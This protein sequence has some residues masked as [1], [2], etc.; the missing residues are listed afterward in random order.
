MIL[1]MVILWMT[2]FIAII[3][4][5]VSDGAYVFEANEILTINDYH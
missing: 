4:N 2:L 5:N 3:F 1:A